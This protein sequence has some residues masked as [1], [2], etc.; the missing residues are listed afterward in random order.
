M[1][2]AYVFPGQGAQ[3]PGMG[4]DLYESSY[5]ARKLFARADKQLGFA[6][7]EVMFKGSAEDL[8][9]T[10]ITQ[11]ALFLHAV[12]AFMTHSERL[13]PCAVAGHSL[14]EFSALVATKALDFEEGLALVRLRAEAM[15]AA[16][17]AQP[18]TMAAVLGLPA[19][20]V[21]QL[22]LNHQDVS[23]ANDNTPTQV[24]ISGT[25]EAIQ[26]ATPTLQNAGA[27]RVLPLAVGGAFHSPFMQ[28]AQHK[29]QL[30]LKDLRFKKPIC[31][32]Y[33]NVDAKPSTD[34]QHIQRQLAR[35]LTQPVLWTQSILN[36]CQ[37]GITHFVECGT[38]NVL[39]GLIKKIN[40]M[41]TTT[42][43]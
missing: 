2:I 1:K 32:I 19:E 31:P 6:I 24:V 18:T 40:P 42:H 16:C 25:K 22:C 29:L 33:Q 36:M 21:R 5:E 7:S 15:Q 38:G 13:A 3:T 28:P 23:V 41:V 30:A 11:P 35:Q 43:L 12:I 14:G 26:S 10:H 27:K 8:R 4:L 34:P 9:Q 17:E 39:Q 37:D 20:K